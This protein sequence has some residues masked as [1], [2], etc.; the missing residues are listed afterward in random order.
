MKLDN[1]QR[2]GIGIVIVGLS[3]FIA[4]TIHLNNQGKVL[5]QGSPTPTPVA[6]PLSSPTTLQHPKQKGHSGAKS[7]DQN[8]AQQHSPPSA[9][10]TTAT[11]ETPLKPSLPD[12]EPNTTLPAGTI[13]TGMVETDLHKRMV[14]QRLA[15]QYMTDTAKNGAPPMEWL[16]L[17]L[18]LIRAN[19]SYYDE[20]YGFREVR[21]SDRL[22]ADESIL[23]AHLQSF[24]PMPLQ[25]TYPQSQ[26]LVAKQIHEALRSAGWNEVTSKVVTDA[27]PPP[28]SYLQLT[29]GT[30]VSDAQRGT[31][32]ELLSE[33]W[34]QGL[35]TEVRYVF[36]SHIAVLALPTGIRTSLAITQE[37]LDLAL[38]SEKS[39]YLV[40]HWPNDQE[41]DSLLHDAFGINTS[42]ISQEQ[43]FYLILASSLNGQ[44][45][46][47][48]N[49][50]EAYIRAFKLDPI[51][52]RAEA[53]TAMNAARNTL[54]IAGYVEYDDKL[55]VRL[56][57]K[58]RHKFLEPSR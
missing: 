29:I 15:V 40:D 55:G 42:S 34:R 3:I 13:R 46:D 33:L 52:G 14:L 32:R 56:S 27:P 7:A 41:A 47:H 20:D 8:Q 10:G 53:T 45:L 43:A 49:A 24:L 2:L 4:E 9:Q 58:Y 23:V 37:T 17:R 57:S 31:A 1:T 19:W 16:K 39:K 36:G 44:E 51:M 54:L 5:S 25:I 30:K 35:P 28:G 22:M 26:S 48:L 18:E 50:R 12:S 6:V 38:R 11:V 21:A